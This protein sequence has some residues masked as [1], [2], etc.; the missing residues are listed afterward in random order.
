MISLSILD[1]VPIS[2]GQSSKNA[3]TNSIE[4]AQLAESL[5]YKRYW[6]AEHHNSKYFA[7]SSPEI[8]ISCIAAQTEKIKVGSG[9]ILLQHYSPYK[10][11]ENLKL[12]DVLYP[13][14]IDAG[15]GRTAGGDE[16]ATQA[17]QGK[18]NMQVPYELKVKQTVDF[19][20]QKEVIANDNELIVSPISDS[21]PEIWLL[22]SG[23]RSAQIAANEGLSFAFGHF[24]TPDDDGKAI[25][26]Y[27]NN[28][29]PSIKQT[30]PHVA[31]C[32]NV[33]CADTDEKCEE[34][35]Q[36]Q[37]LMTVL[38]DRG[39][40]PKGTPSPS[41]VQKF[42]YTDKEKEIIK[43]SR[44]ELILGTPKKVRKE[45]LNLSKK[46]N[47]DEILILT[48]TYDHMDRLNSYKLIMEEM[49][50]DVKRYNEEFSIL[51]T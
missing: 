29:K 32:I 28:F 49:K 7:N 37:D 20:T 19:L 51:T 43:K 47:A 16:I 9:G 34:I 45:I 3:L 4:L 6:I 38:L 35:A 27:L 36:S 48:I 46:Y 11:A 12:L 39:L 44:Q 41:D 26:Y 31:L 17:L 1:Q 42:V 5:G 18:H 24:L 25:E 40:H 30:K 15:F 13:D 14:R 23:M 10:V 50:Y 22:G 2:D 21:S 33:I 8:L